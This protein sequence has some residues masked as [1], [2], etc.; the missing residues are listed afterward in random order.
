[1][2]WRSRAGSKAMPPG[3]WAF[4]VR[5]CSTKSQNSSWR[6]IAVK[7]FKIPNALTLALLGGLLI[8]SVVLALGTPVVSSNQ[9]EKLFRDSVGD[10]NSGNYGEAEKGF[11]SIRSEEADNLNAHYPLGLVK[12]EQRMFPEALTFFQWVEKRAPQMPVVHYYLGLIAYDQENW[13]AAL[14]EME[15]A[16]N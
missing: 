7:S 4:P 10:L 14:K 13:D 6:V 3:N 9:Q 16:E 5:H 8:P 11:Q 1:M 15:N 2:L 12:Y